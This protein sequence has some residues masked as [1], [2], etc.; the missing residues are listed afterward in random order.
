MEHIQQKCI[1]ILMIV[2]IISSIYYM[3]QGMFGNIL[4][5]LIF[6]ALSYIGLTLK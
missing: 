1:K 2:I 6:G 4:M 3:S 5:V